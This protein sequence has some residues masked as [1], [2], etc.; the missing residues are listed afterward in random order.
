MA[1]KVCGI[2][3]FVEHPTDLC[4]T[5]QETESDQLENVGAIGPIPNVPQ[6]SAGYQ[7]PSPQY[8]ALTFQQQQQIIP[9][10]GNSPSLEDLM[11][12]LVANNLEFQQSQHTVLAKYKRHHPRPQDADRT[13]SEHCE[14][15]TVSRIHQPSLTNNS[16]SERERECSTLRSGKEL[17][18]PA[19]QLPRST[20]ADVELDANSQVQQEEKTVRL[21]FPTWTFS[22]RK[23]ESNKELLKMFCKVEINIP[24]LDAIKQIPRYAKF[25]K[26]HLHHGL[27]TSAI[28]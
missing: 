18:Q 27:Q 14:P 8:Q 5:L 17:S 16:K 24:L 9:P 1:T 23:S 6:G 21:S 19:S 3:T 2:C 26:Q 12:Q 11:K 10:E 22:T 25:L 4:P 13:I 7:Q 20:E 28:L 15:F